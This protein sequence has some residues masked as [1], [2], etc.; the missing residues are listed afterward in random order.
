MIATAT[1]TPSTPTEPKPP[2]RPRPIRDFA[3]AGLSPALVESLVLK[4]LLNVGMAT[5]RR[6]A[7]RREGLGMPRSA[8]LNPLAAIGRQD[9]RAAQL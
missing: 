7:D 4:F 2:F 5:G 6:I 9:G 1:T 3:T 8:A